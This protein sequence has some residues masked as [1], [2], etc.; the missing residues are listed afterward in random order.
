[1]YGSV[2][3]FVNNEFYIVETLYTEESVFP[4]EVI[5][6]DAYPNPFNPVTNITFSLPVSM[7]I[8]LNVIDIQGRLV[9]TLMNGMQT[10]GK[11]HAV[12][13]GDDLSSGVYFVQLITNEGIYYSKVI[14]LK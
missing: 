3:D 1:M 4:T 5:L 9:K 2:D 14:L 8:Q 11:H 13:S 12:F 10:E 6:E 7:D